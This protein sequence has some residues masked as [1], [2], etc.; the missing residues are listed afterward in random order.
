MKTKLFI[1]L[2]ILMSA[3]AGCGSKCDHEYS[4]FIS[5]N[6][7]KRTYIVGDQFD[8][9]GLQ[10]SKKCSKCGDLQ[11]V[12]FELEVSHTLGLDDKKATITCEGVTLEYEFFVKE[13]Y[14][15]A[16]CGDS[17]TAGHYWANESYPTYLSQYVSD[18][19]TVENCGV[20]GISI[21]GYGG[22]WDDPEMRYIKQDVYQKSVNFKPDIFAIMLGTNDATGW[23][24]AKDIYEDEYRVLLDS[25]IELFPNAKFIMMV[26]PPVVTPNQFGIPN[27][28]IR[29]YVNPI[30]RDLADEYGFEVLDLREEFEA[31]DGFESK[32]L[33]PNNDN[34]HFTKEGAQYVANRVWEI[35]KDLT[36]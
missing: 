22:S 7:D 30:Q 36:F 19:Y 34:V 25:Y 28:E 16:C 6:S 2:P 12:N 1:L 10:V 9:T 31:I 11:K 13:K 24:K 20:N 29:D 27:D 18:K 17:L 14:H 35:A 23:E 5:R 33:R 32:F 3:L 15:I 21:T 8:P 4:Y 26:S